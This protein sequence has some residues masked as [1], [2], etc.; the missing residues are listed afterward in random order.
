[1]RRRR[2]SSRVKLNPDCVWA[3]QS[4]RHLSQNELAA[5]VGTSS[6]YLSQL[7]CG[8]RSPSAELRRRLVDVLG[9]AD[10]D[11]LFVLEPVEP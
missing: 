4:R 3:L 11:D 2:A 6:G 7:M 8:K 10:F 9:V 5:L 1:M